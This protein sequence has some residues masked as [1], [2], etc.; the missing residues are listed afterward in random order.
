MRRT[1]AFVVAITAAG[2]LLLAGCSSSTDV[3]SIEQTVQGGLAEQ[4]GGTWTVECPDSMTVEA[5]LTADCMATSDS[6]EAIDV[7][8]TQTDDQGAV[9]WEVPPSGFD[10]ASAE[11]TVATEMGAELGGEW[12]VDCPEDIP[13]Q[14]DLTA[15]CGATD[16]DGK[17]VMV[18][19]TQIDDRGTVTWK[20][21]E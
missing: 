11:A 13:T 14:K 3:A 17:S 18:D 5:G 10:E 8:I 2:G 7:S 15:N 12:T 16:A 1:G 6:G 21:A 4:R 20:V 9:T 19:L